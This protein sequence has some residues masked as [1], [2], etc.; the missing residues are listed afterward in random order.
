M[1]LENNKS[2]SNFEKLAAIIDFPIEDGIVSTNLIKCVQTSSI[3]VNEEELKLLKSDIE[4]R[5][6]NIDAQLIEIG[7]L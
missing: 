5:I 7:K 4:A 1:S 3:T 6:A 2:Q